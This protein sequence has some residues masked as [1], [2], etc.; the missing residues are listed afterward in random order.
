M[1]AYTTINDPGLFFN[2]K[3][4][5]GSAGVQS[6]T[7]VGCTPNMAWFKS[8][9]S[10]ASHQLYDTVRG[11]ASALVPSTNAAPIDATGDGFTSLDSDGYTFNGSG[12]GGNVNAAQDFV[13][14]NWKAGTTS[15]ITGGT[16]TP[17]SY[18][19]NTTSGFGIYAYTGT[20]ANATIAH[21]LGTAPHH[22]ICKRLDTTG[23]WNGWDIGLT[24]GSYYINLNTTGAEVSNAAVW[25]STVPSSTL[26]SLGTYAAVNAS[27]STYIMYVFAPKKGYSA[28]GSYTGTGDAS[29]S[30]FINT[31]F[32]P[33]YVL[34]KRSNSSGSWWIFDN[35]RLGY[36]SANYR[37]YA[38]ADTAEDT[39]VMI[40]LLSNGF[41]LRTTDSEMN[42]SGDD[43][44]YM[45]FAEA[46]FV[47]AE[48]V[49]CNAR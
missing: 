41:K 49:A 39:T 9:T 21:G 27:S 8:R 3:L 1:A 31:G 42:A 38:N 48:G 22:V 45:T 25:N 36:N 24:S 11:N 23:D 2:P 4:Y 26:V 14:W 33:A 40:D 20:G 30:P 47:N 5:T 17:S 44:M 13:A 18:S 16:I 34:L 12:G 43:F 37:I 15:G 35:K 10:V 19:I 6:I 29:I 46:P 7:G 32:K 28:F